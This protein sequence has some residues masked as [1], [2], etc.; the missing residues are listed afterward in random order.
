MKQFVF[1]L[2]IIVATAALG[3]NSNMN[4]TWNVKDN[5]AGKEGESVCM[6]TQKAMDFSG[7]CKGDDGNVDITGK[8]DGRRVSWQLKSDYNGQTLTVVYTGTMDSDSTITGKI[9]VQPIGASGDFTAKK[10]K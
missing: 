9:D 3:A 7:T 10:A 6:L 5:I 2:L 1:V 4:G 8:V